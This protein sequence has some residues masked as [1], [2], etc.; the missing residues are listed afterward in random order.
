ME[1]IWG[2][3]VLFRFNHPEQRCVVVGWS[4]EFYRSYSSEEPTMDY[5]AQ[6]YSF[7]SDIRKT[8]TSLH[9]QVEREVDIETGIVSLDAYTHKLCQFLGLF[10]CLERQ[11]L[12]VPDL[13]RWLPDISHRQRVPALLRDL[14]ALGASSSFPESPANLTPVR[15]VADAFGCLY[16]LEG[17]TLGGQIIARK[18]ESSL[19][20]TS[21]H[22]CSFFSGA[23]RNVAEKW[24]RFRESIQAFADSD[25]VHPPAIVAA[26]VRTFEVFI[27]W[28]ANHKVPSVQNA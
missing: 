26:A 16:V 5:G 17:S 18:L 12:A 15:T 10:Q 28:F 13:S 21:E 2:R 11:I 7:L 8:T 25:A 20:L 1:S 9:A 19:G 3:L 24:L 14:R 6:K 4:Q 27:A 22:G 23:D